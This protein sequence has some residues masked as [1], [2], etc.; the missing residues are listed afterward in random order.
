MVDCATPV[1]VYY[2]S[3]QL[4]KRFEKLGLGN[5]LQFSDRQSAAN[6]RHRRL[7]VPK[8]L[9][10]F[11]NSPKMEIFSPKF[12]IPGGIFSD[13]KK[14]FLPASLPRRHS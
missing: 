2:N 3:Q 12:C 5:K 1:T 11:S 4:R 13:K 14:K 7:Q 8:S 10:L 9:I 6:F